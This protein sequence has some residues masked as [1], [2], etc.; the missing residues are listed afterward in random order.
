VGGVPLRCMWRAFMNIEYTGCPSA[1][2]AAVIAPRA[3]T[4]CYVHLSFGRTIVTFLLIYRLP[5]TASAGRAGYY[6][7]LLYLYSSKI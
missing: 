7:L 5:G 3:A 1:A 6:I 4:L 2:A